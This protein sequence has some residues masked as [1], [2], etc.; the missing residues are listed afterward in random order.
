MRALLF[1]TVTGNP[2]LDLQVSDWSCD[3]GILAA[4]A[5]KVTVPARSAWASS[6][7]LRALLA[8]D[9]HAVALV[10][11]SGEGVSV[12]RAAGVI[13][14]ATPQEGE[15]GEHSYEVV[16]RGPE[17]LLE[18]RQ[19]RLFPGW[20]LLSAGGLPTG[21]YDQALEGLSY[22]TIMKR[23]VSETEKFPGGALPIVYEADRGGVHERAS[24]LAVDGKQV[25][26]A[27]DQLADLDDGVEYDFQPQIDELDRVSWRLVT[28][29]DTERV[30]YGETSWLWNIGGVQPDIRGYSREPA[31]APLITDTV[32]TGG[33]DDDTLLLAR[34]QLHG[35]LAEGYPRM[36]L[37]D[38]SHSTVSVQSTLQAW[39][40]G[41][42]GALPDQ[43]SFDV[44]ASAAHLVRHGD[45]GVLAAQGHWDIADGDYDVR[46]L[47]VSRKAS[48]A[49]W[50]N[51]KLV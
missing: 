12:V 46:V 44:R 7:D 15:G 51:I 29:S 42:L 40:N 6:L 5:L 17:R 31:A 45:F 36:E 33:K 11:E 9:K 25:L 18:W 13:V 47:A 10:D 32:F 14:T 30:V 38:S 48:E 34:G 23:L 50:V 41:A 3:T 1:E 39:A 49:D 37:W 35:P 4:D 2:V 24:Y 28:G 19:V 20:P 22:G 16:C 27:L 8:R 21:T 26:E 43:V